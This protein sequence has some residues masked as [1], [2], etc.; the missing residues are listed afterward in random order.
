[1]AAKADRS[2]LI[3]AIKE[4]IDLR[5]MIDGL[6]NRSGR[7]FRKCPFHAGGNERTG[8]LMV[9][10]DHYW[11]FACSQ[12]GD[13]FDW[14]EKTRGLGFTEALVELSAR[15]GISFEEKDVQA[16]LQRSRAREEVTRT[17]EAFRE[18]ADP[19]REYLRGRGLN[20]EIIDLAQIGYSPEESAVVLP[21][22][23]PAGRPIGKSLRY[24][25]PDAQPR[26]RT[27]NNPV[28]QLRDNVWGLQVAL[29][30]S[31]ERLWLVEGQI[32]C[33]SLWQSGRQRAVAYVNGVLTQG[34]TAQLL[35]Y[36]P[37]CEW[38][39]VCDNKTENDWA[40]FER[41]YARVQEKD[42]D[43]L[44]RVCVPPRGMDVNDA[45]RAGTLDFL[46]DIQPVPMVQAKNIVSNGMARD[47]QYQAA[48]RLYRETRDALVRDDLVRLF[49]EA[50]ERDA[51]AVREYCDAPADGELRAQVVDVRYALDLAEE[52]TDAMIEQGWHLGFPQLKRL[53]RYPRPKQLM[54]I[55]A[56]PGVGKTTFAVN[57]IRRMRDLRL[58]TLYI[59]Y[60]QPSYE[61][62]LKLGL[63]TAFELNRSCV[64]DEIYG[65]I[66]GRRDDSYWSWMRD[67]VAQLYSHVYFCDDCP[68]TDEVSSLV[69]QYNMRLTAP[70]EVVI[71]DYLQI[72]PGV[73]GGAS[74]EYEETT[75][76]MRTIR[77]A[78]LQGNQLY[79]LL[80]QTSRESGR[81]GRALGLEAGKGS[82]AIEAETDYLLTMWPG[83]HVA[84]GVEVN[85]ALA[86]NKFGET[87]KFELWRD[88][89]HAL[90]ESRLM[91]VAERDSRDRIAAAS[92]RTAAVAVPAVGQAVNDPWAPDNEED[93][94]A[95]ED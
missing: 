33:M 81:G 36:F 49:A 53:I 78:V 2:G 48:K 82:G 17:L 65:R 15:L 30:G 70:V 32:D 90:M 88:G 57:L 84:G 69:A 54:T 14:L 5:E 16:L 18:A 46:D 68:A 1:M 75:A 39:F 51:S 74:G 21:F 66:Y 56:Q 52:T 79:M 64:Y 62:I 19:A 63:A 44:C 76:K 20:D 31:G 43:R 73:R 60:E 6:E 4:R 71:I 9:E 95:E 61:L 72:M 7:M 41:C 12:Y 26:Y 22:C 45:L 34:Q 91:P 83:E 94:F 8:S 89:A 85:C 67:M 86:K 40:V 10:K 77:A 58:P 92:W 50:W 27:F 59:S 28:F 55:V 35:R 87:G 29:R 38:V 47:A 3:D 11:C 42:P 80:S 37:D 13:V 93:P 25:D 24:L 23:D